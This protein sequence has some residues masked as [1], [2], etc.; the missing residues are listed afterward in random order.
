MTHLRRVKVF[1]IIGAFAAVWNEKNILETKWNYYNRFY[2]EPT[3]LQ[4]TLVQEAQI[5]KDRE[6]AGIPETQIEDKRFIDPESQQIYSQ[7]YQLPP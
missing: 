4:R 2:P 3:Q 1:S 5:M 6:A 7:F